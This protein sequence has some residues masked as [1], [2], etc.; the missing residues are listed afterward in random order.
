MS[1]NTQKKTYFKCLIYVSDKTKPNQKQK[2]KREEHI[3]TFEV[4]I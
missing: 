1:K 3:D 4:I 2:H